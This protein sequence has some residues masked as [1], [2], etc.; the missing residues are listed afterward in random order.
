MTR[1]LGAVLVVLNLALLATGCRD[2]GPG[3]GNKVSTVVYS[4]DGTGV[5]DVAYAATG[6]D[7]LTVQEGVGLPWRHEAHVV[8][9]SGIV[10]RVTATSPVAA[11]LDCAIEVN[12][13][14]VRPTRSV[15]GHTL[16]CSFVK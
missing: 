8:D 15:E 5:A 16:T 2:M 7:K 12:G 11:D 13:V 6:G 9:R 14:G 4:V 10:Y 3:G 1:R